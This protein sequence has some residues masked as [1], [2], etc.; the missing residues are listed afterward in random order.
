VSSTLI[1]E[2]NRAIPKTETVDPNRAKFLTLNAEPKYKPSNTDNDDP[3]ALQP[4]RL[5]TDPILTKLLTEME[6]PT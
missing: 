1:D 2:A 6:E 4:N 5:I 3:Q